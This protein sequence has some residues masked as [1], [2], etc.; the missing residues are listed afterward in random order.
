MD[1]SPVVTLLGFVI[2]TAGFIATVFWRSAQM[3]KSIMDHIDEQNGKLW[4]KHHEL[5]DRQHDLA[6]GLAEH[7]LEMSNHYASKVDLHDTYE[8]FTTEM[9]KAVKRVE[10]Q[11]AKLERS[12][13]TKR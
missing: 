2:A 9:E 10:V 6:L 7:K 11:I 13:E 3:Q 12:L 4:N 1:I 5:R 8:R